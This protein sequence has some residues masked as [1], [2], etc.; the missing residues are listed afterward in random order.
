MTREEAI[1]VLESMKSEESYNALIDLCNMAI[2]SLSAE[3]SGDEWEEYSEK[4]W[5][6]AF[7]RGQQSVRPKG[8]WIFDGE[9]VN[10]GIK[11]C[12]CSVC[13]KTDTANIID[14]YHFCPNCGASMVG[15]AEM[16]GDAE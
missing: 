9:K 14:R 11:W 15:G 7:E 10:G 5:K 1:Q 16:R 12:H 6:L 13:G 8:E 2:E 3:P 4:L